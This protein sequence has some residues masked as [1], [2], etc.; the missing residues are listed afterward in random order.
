MTFGKR[1]P[2]LLLLLV[3]YACG[4]LVFLVAHTVGL[5][6]NRLA[7]RN[8]ALQPG[9]LALQDFELAHHLVEEEG[10]LHTTGT[11]PQLVLK[12]GERHVENVTL[13]VVYAQPPL[14]VNVY[15]AKPGQDYSLARIAYPTQN[16][17]KH[18]LLPP[19]GGQGLRLDLG[20]VNGNTIQFISATVNQKRPVWQFYLPSAGEVALLVVAPGLAACFL[21]VLAGFGLKPPRHGKK[22]AKPTLTL[23]PGGKGGGGK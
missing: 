21:S 20:S 19:A 8:G 18:F 14:M 11:D 23:V 22:Q 15:W 2:G 6:Q 9:V 16:G 3:C 5:V 4:L 17:G 10:V 12:D 13:E 7:Y 1:H